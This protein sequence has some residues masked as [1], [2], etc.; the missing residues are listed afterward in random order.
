MIYLDD[1]RLTG[2][3]GVRLECTYISTRNLYRTK[4]MFK[5]ILTSCKCKKT[6][7]IM[8][9]KSDIAINHEVFRV[10]QNYSEAL[11]SPEVN[12]KAVMNVKIKMLA[13]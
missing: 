5:S 7:R 1:E 3:S 10:N 4:I 12:M 2:L 6:N 11:S 9:K 13:I 8:Q